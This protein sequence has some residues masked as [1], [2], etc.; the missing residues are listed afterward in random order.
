MLTSPT[1]RPSTAQVASAASPCVA[2]PGMGN[3][4]ALPSST[5]RNPVALIAASVTGISERARRS[6]SSSSI[7]I[8]T[9]A[10]GAANTAAM[11]PA[12]PAAS[13][14]LRSRR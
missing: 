3:I 2:M 7:A 4:G 12:A 10:N 8:S 1:T 9:A 11:P 5:K 6:N 13:S 14:V